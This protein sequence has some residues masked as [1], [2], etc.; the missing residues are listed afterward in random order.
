MRDESIL[1]LSSNYGE[2]HEQAAKAIQESLHIEHPNVESERI[3]YMAWS[4]PY[5]NRMS[6]YIFLQGVKSF[7]SAYGYLYNKTKNDNTFSELLKKGN[8]LGS[9]RLLK[10][11][12]T[13]KPSLVVSTF[14]M[15]A[16][17]MS[18][19]KQVG[20][21]DVSTT[22]VIT[23]HSHHN[24][25][26]YPRTDSYCVG[27]SYVKESLVMKHIPSEQIF[28]T[29]IPIRSEFSQQ[30]YTKEELMRKHGLDPALPTLLLM[31]GGYGLFGDGVSFLRSL[32]QIP[33]QM[34]CLIICGRNRHMQQQLTA[35][36]RSSKHKVYV[37]GYIDYVSEM[38]QVSDL[39]VTKPGGLTISEALAME[40]P[41]ILYN[42]LPGQEE[43][44]AKFLIHA[45]AALKANKMK[46]LV[47]TI[48]KVFHDPQTL[49]T[50]K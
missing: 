33:Y 10:L 38:M 13:T 49:Q 37:K 9:S 20:L 1:I 24:H 2:G 40:L 42:A 17:A 3:D 27:S 5:V 39:I 4:H 30:T 19:L 15:A 14:P 43:D 31:G 16:G 47:E 28:V 36:S 46:Q 29:G 7:P 25:W 23:D 48:G 44:N 8:R 22:T 12:Q 18:V 41:M 26:I 6:R 50:M 21:T 34:Q 45:G 32:E 35:E 11:L